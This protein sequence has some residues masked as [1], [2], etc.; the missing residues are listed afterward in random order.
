MPALFGKDDKHRS[1]CSERSADIVKSNQRNRPVL[2]LTY[3]PSNLSSIYHSPSGRFL[4]QCIQR[5][6]ANVL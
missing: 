6:K 3:F 5:L 4:R 2:S 1:Q